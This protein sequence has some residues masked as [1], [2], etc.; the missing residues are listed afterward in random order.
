ML[1][2]SKR[3]GIVALLVLPAFFT[4]SIQSP[5]ELFHPIEEGLAPAPPDHIHLGGPLVEAQTDS[6]DHGDHLCAH[7]GAV[8]YLPK[9]EA[10]FRSCGTVAAADLNSEAAAVRTPLSIFERGPPL[11]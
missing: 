11:L 1:T 8:G 3:H 4:F 7:S 6:I 10:G 2:A 9:P 5:L